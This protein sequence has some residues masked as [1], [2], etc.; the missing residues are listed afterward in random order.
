MNLKKIFFTLFC[1][2]AALSCFLFVFAASPEEERLQID[3][4][5]PKLK[6]RMPAAPREEWKAREVA[7]K[8]A[9]LKGTGRFLIYLPPGY[10]SSKKEYPVVYF[11][12]GM[13]D[14]HMTW[15]DG[16][17]EMDRM[18]ALLMED[19]DAV[20]MIL[21]APEGGRGFWSNFKDGSVLY[22][23]W[24]MKDVFAYIEKNYRVLKK[25]EGRAVMG[26]SM[27]GFGA[28][29]IAMR[30]PEIFGCVCAIAPAIP[31]PALPP[32][33]SALSRIF[34]SDQDQKYYRRN[35]PFWL[36]EEDPA[37]LRNMKFILKCG[38]ADGL[39]PSVAGYADFMKNNG[40][41]CR[42]QAYKD[43]K[44]DV[45]FFRKSSVDALM[46]ISDFFNKKK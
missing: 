4:V 26:V 13:G 8:S 6:G 14:S 38:T 25:R 36:V 45:F 34:G 20:P 15:L 5:V 2:V 42:W 22:E 39:Y 16:Q 31:P 10:S 21:V 19:G 32:G 27:G 1:A 37:G 9:S 44:H 11:L 43:M 3:S 41:D 29:K 46:Q 17:Q 23:D 30:H 24:V 18:A 33:N 35:H 12:H 7:I 40:M 28:L